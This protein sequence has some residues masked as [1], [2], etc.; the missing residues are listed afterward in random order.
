MHMASE[1]H[2]SAASSAASCSCCATHRQK[3]FR[4]LYDITLLG[5]VVL[6]LCKVL[7]QDQQA[8]STGLGKDVAE[9]GRQEIPIRS[10]RQA[11][12]T[13]T[14]PKSPSTDEV[15][16]CCP[17]GPPGIRGT[18]G[19][20]GLTGSNGLPGEIGDKGNQGSPG[21]KGEKGQAIISDCKECTCPH[22]HH[23]VVK[24]YTS[25]SEHN[26][27]PIKKDAN[28]HSWFIPWHLRNKSDIHLKEFG[29]HTENKESVTV[30]SDGVFLIS[31]TITVIQADTPLTM[32]INTSS[33]VYFLSQT[34]TNINYAPDGSQIGCT[35]S[36]YFLGFLQA[37]EVIRVQMTLTNTSRSSFTDL[38]VYNYD[39]PALQIV[40]LSRL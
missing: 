11:E 23:A 25:G 19:D 33:P 16:H 39:Q 24:L 26:E 28:T 13:Y 14:V 7:M 12:C 38:E 36:G 6:L 22:N 2:R 31:C 17:P 27:S 1:N 29:F 35:Y 9:K 4:C 34:R 8:A 20:R 18:K 5:V 21:Y 3:R 10:K 32:S 40:L 37:N 30:L 15:C